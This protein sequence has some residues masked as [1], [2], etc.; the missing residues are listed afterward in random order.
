MISNKKYNIIYADPPWKFSNKNTGGSMTSG[1]ANKYSTM[2]LREICSLPIQDMITNDSILFMWWVASMPQE[3]LQVV[4]H[5]GFTL[6]TMTAFTWMKQTVHGKD[7]F[8]MGFWTRQQCESCLV[9]VRGKPKRVNASVREI[10]RAQNLKHSQ[11]PS[12]V[13][14]RIVDLCGDLPRI[15]LFART[16]VDKWDAWGEEV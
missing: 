15:E 9:A 7:H 10:V 14:E 5:W 4:K 12:I 8:G 2:T 6:K 16:K 11:K 13:H 1:S 3:A